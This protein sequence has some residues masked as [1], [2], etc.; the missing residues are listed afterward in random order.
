[1]VH[2][3]VITLLS[4]ALSLHGTWPVENRPFWTEQA[5]FHFGDDVFFTGR[6]SCAPNAEDGRQRAYVAA[7]QEVKNF[8]RTQEVGGFPIETQMIFEDQHPE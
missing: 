8:S 7:I 4:L 3:L 2:Y 6:A 5:L 1:M